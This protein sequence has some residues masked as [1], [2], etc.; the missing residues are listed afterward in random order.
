MVPLNI[1]EDRAL[2]FISASIEQRT[3]GFFQL[4]CFL[5]FFQIEAKLVIQDAFL[6]TNAPTIQFQKEFLEKQNT[7][8]AKRGDTFY[9]IANVW[10]KKLN[11]KINGNS[12][13]TAIEAINNYELIDGFVEF[14]KLKTSLR[15]GEDFVLVNENAW[16][17]LLS[18]YTYD[19]FYYF[20]LAFRSN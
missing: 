7:V 3:S 6:M 15:E 5:I 2:D 18:W 16:K 20:Y 10:W 14:G 11:E 19:S 17:A 4:T 9:L 13:E 8:A 12:I 1:N